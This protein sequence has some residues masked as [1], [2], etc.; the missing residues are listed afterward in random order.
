MIISCE[1]EQ[2]G[3]DGEV[4]P[5]TSLTEAGFT[6]E[7]GGD[8]RFGEGEGSG[9]GAE[10]ISALGFP[11]EETGGGAGGAVVGGD[12]STEE[13]FPTEKAGL[14]GVRGSGEG[15]DVNG[16]EGGGGGGGDE[17][18]PGD[19]CVCNARP[20]CHTIINDRVIFC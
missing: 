8:A 18:G 6:T 14:G 16:G 19:V 20:I 13:E 12:Y 10:D 3:A 11:S 15:V 2:T 5:M 4:P 17:L 7:E 1:Q 9:I